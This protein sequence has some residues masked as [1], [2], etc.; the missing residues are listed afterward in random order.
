[1]PSPPVAKRVRNETEL[2]GRVL[3]DDYAWLR[4]RDDPDTLA[5]LQAEN[6]YAETW[7]EP[8]AP[9]RQAIF[10]EI[11]ARTEETDLSAPVRKGAWSYYHRTAEGLPYP[12][13]ARRDDTG[14]E[15][16]LLD[17]NREAEGHEFFAVGAFEV[18]P[19]HDLLA[20]SADVNGSEVYE[21]RFR[22]LA[23][24]TD[25]PDRIERTFGGA[26]WSLDGRY[27]FYQVP[28]DTMRPFQVWRHELGRPS[29]DDVLV[30]EEPDERFYVDLGLTRS[31]RFVVIM[32]GSRT[33][34]EVSVI[35]A[36]A[37]LTPA[38]VVEPRREGHEYSLDHWGDRFV[39][40][41]NDEAEDFRVVTAPLARP[42]RAQ[43]VELVAHRAGRRI[44]DA[45]AFAGHLVLSEWE[46]AQP[47]LRILFADGHE[48]RLGFDDAGY[49][50]E[51]DAN[52]E[53]DT[54]NVR[55][56]YQSLVTPP[57]VYDEDVVTEVRTLVKQTPVLGGYDPAD[58]ETA[59]EWA[60]ASDGARVPIDLVW[61]RTTPIDGTAAGVIYGYG[62]YE[63]S[64]PPY[65]SIARFSLLDRGG[66]FALVHPRGG[67]ELGRQW[68]LN[69]KLRHKRNTF[70]DT[71]A[72]ADHLVEHR[73]MASDRVGLRGGSAGGLL[74]GACINFRPARWRA[75]LAAVPFVDVVNTMLD[76]TLPLTVTERDEWGDPR[77]PEDAA[78]IES[79]SPYENVAAVDY[80]AILVTA[81]LN[82]PRVSYHEPAKWVA[83]LRA[84]AVGDQP[85]LLWTELV[86]GHQGPSGRYEAWKEEARNLAFLLH[87]LALD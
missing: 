7:F 65:F 33:T 76:P 38:A 45:A 51:L 16:V 20:W 10:D 64:V 18:S 68:Y 40:V 42:G 48:R 15:S 54:T 12:I 60:T 4:N 31:E 71:I 53:Y 23:G 26:A 47:G 83:K 82:D 8:L 9:L 50:I 49:D 39:I 2:H 84:T 21:L 46:D 25:L 22:E 79:Y 32:S 56:H 52:P 6:A 78:Y 59:R 44:N 34:S 36:D 29:A 80:P 61:K 35:P 66:V 27:C 85:L 69:G 55:F 3:I 17:E 62:A 86:A 77:Q 72:C 57:G 28:D 87:E 63:I 70:T 58:Y 74:V 81:G 1:V 11:K 43:W 75:A 24:G 19:D 67:G 5:Y 13:H 30:Y 14:T 37:P 41:T 73:Y